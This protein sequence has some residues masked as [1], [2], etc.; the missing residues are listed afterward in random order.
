MGK[1]Y[2]GM[3]LEATRHHDKP[4]EW[5]VEKAAEMGYEY[6]EPMVHWGRELMSEAG[7]YHTV[8]MMDVRVTTSPGWRSRCSSRLNSLGVRSI[9]RSARLTLRRATFI[10]RS[11]HASSPGAMAPERRCSARNRASSSGK[12]KGLTR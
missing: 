3:N 5:G 7:Y 4:F 9:S 10:T 12:A 8:S 1:I 2:V 11:A 6:I